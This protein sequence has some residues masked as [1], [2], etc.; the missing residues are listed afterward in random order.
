MRAGT[1]HYT[2]YWYTVHTTH[3]S[4]V[5]PHWVPH[6]SHTRSPQLVGVNIQTL[7]SSHCSNIKPLHFDLINC[8]WVTECCVF[9]Q[10]LWKN[11]GTILRR[12]L[13][14]EK[15]RQSLEMMGARCPI[16]CGQL[17]WQPGPRLPITPL[18]YCSNLNNT[19]KSQLSIKSA[20]SV[21]SRC[22]IPMTTARRW[23]EEV[24]SKHRH[25][26]PDWEWSMAMV[27]AQT[28]SSKFYGKY[29]NCSFMFSWDQIR[30]KQQQPLTTRLLK[31]ALLGRCSQQVC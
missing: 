7:P 29:Q 30:A 14:Y 25:Q 28:A 8:C 9:S 6:H 20:P 27:A 3:Y 12:T 18:L 10:S 11:W 4:P 16:Q 2:G 15:R 13:Q 23:D 26:T 19:F 31:C 1:R 5:S 21:I 24:C 17:D 22:H